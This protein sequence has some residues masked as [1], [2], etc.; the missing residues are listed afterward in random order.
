MMSH[1]R[2]REAIT[3]L[4]VECAEH[5]VPTQVIRDQTVYF[6]TL[7]YRGRTNTFQVRVEDSSI[8]FGTAAI[9]RCTISELDGVQ[10]TVR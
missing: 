6:G 8:S 5:N 9:I 10:I 4:L 3:E 2:I 7:V 1:L